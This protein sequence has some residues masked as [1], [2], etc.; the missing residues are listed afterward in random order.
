M[1]RLWTYCGRLRVER[2]DG[3][4]VHA[5][6]PLPEGWR[7]GDAAPQRLLRKATA[8]R[9]AVPGMEIGDVFRIDFD[10]GAPWRP[11]WVSCVDGPTCEDWKRRDREA[12]VAPGAESKPRVPVDQALATLRAHYFGL[13]ESERATWLER[14]A[15]RIQQ[16]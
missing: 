6:L 11:H 5:Y 14:A 2:L 9:D 8:F 4:I 3:M 1:K 7:E 10:A 12:E 16:P 15:K 13:P